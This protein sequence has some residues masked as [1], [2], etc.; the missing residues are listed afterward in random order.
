MHLTPGDIDY[1]NTPEHPLRWDVSEVKAIM[2]VS[3]IGFQIKYQ[4]FQ[5]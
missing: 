3:V 4:F 1:I 5:P 2:D